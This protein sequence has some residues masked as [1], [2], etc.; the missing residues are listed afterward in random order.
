MG[1]AAAL[2]TGSA[3]VY[4]SSQVAISRESVVVPFLK[5][6]RRV[7]AVSDLHMP[8]LYNSTADLV[9]AINAES[10]DVFVLAGDTIDKRGNEGLVRVLGSVSVRLAKFASLGNWEYLGKLNLRRLRD[11]YE[12]AEI[13]LLMNDVSEFGDLTIVGLDD[14]VE[15][16]PDYQLLGNSSFA[17]SPVLVVS[18]C[19][20]SFD[21]IAE[22]FR[23]PTV[24]LSG[25]T[26]GGQIAPFG[27]VLHTP[28]GS[29]PY[30]RGWYQKGRHLMYV[31][32][33][34]GATPGLPFRIGA[35]PELLVLDLLPAGKA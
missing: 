29:G 12:K 21:R 34:I 20:A 14:L 18:H 22:S 13:S 24:V 11:E 25:H 32:R 15:G 10:P 23:C 9:K 4:R 26:H 17:K 6:R 16:S 30:V 8:C 33:G 35:R 2:V 5:K 3:Y 1:S 19:P 7:V 31:M 28:E 27:V